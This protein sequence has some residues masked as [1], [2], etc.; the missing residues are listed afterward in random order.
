MSK[1]INTI[2][3]LGDQAVI[4]GLLNGSLEEFCDDTITEMSARAFSKNGKIACVNIP[5]LRAVPSSAF[6]NCKSLKRLI[7]SS[8]IMCPLG[9]WVFNGTPIESGTGYIYVP[10]AL[11][12]TYKTATNWSTFANQFRALEDYTVDGTV[13]GEID[14][15]KI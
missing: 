12:D 9:E 4:D 8:E 14:E 6:D 10:R 1:F 2:D 5:N 15:S 13:T 3:L 11:V 7:L